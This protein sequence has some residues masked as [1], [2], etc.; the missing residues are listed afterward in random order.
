[1]G[2]IS[3][4]MVCKAWAL[5]R[6]EGKGWGGVWQGV[7]EEKRGGKDERGRRRMKGVMR[8][9][10]TRRSTRRFVDE[11]MTLKKLIF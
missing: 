3:W 5:E 2:V 4:N 7:R 8:Y 1:M 6:R 11:L 9:V 10:Y